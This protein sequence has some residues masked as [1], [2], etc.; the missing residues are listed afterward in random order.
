[1]SLLVAD[2]HPMLLKGLTDELTENGFNVAATAGNG[3]EALNLIA[4]LQP[5]VA[6]LDIEMPLLSGFE[7]I[8]KSRE[9]N[10]STKFILLTS[11]K[12]KGFVLRAKKFNISGYILK[13]EPFVELEKCIHAVVRN[14]VY[15]STAFDEVFT[16]QVSP[17]LEKIKFLSPSE[18][19]IVR[20]VAQEKSSKE[21][22][23]ILYI[24]HRTVQKHRTNII[25]KLDLPASGDALSLWTAENRE[26]I[27]SL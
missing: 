15:F 16:T 27:L 24:S 5:D 1:M 26:L 21:I 25:A 19:T 8:K 10:V 22:A 7:V 14:E 9:K 11:H 3:A 4:E 18:R 12:E 17:E 20:L 13:D 6:I 23:E 2:D